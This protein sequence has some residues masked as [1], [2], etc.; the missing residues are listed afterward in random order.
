MSFA[1][2]QA[3]NGQMADINITPL[4]DVMLVLLV[5]F[6]LAVPA[7]TYRVG[8][9]FPQA[10][11]GAPPPIQTLQLRID[12][13]D[14]LAL[15]GVSMSRQELGEKLA[16]ALRIA[17]KPLVIEIIA[18]ADAEYGDVTTTLATARNAGVT[19]LVFVDH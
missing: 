5:I 1:V 9:A 13:G 19:N 15:D 18:S 6:M 3:H 12:A 17:D 16:S 2:L 4:V 7:I 14:T 11:T 8:Y 10:P